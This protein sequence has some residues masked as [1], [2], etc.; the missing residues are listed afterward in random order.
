M[1]KKLESVN[2]LELWMIVLLVIDGILICIILE[3]NPGAALIIALV[4][5]TCIIVNALSAFYITPFKKK[6]F[7]GKIVKFCG[8]ILLLLAVSLY[9]WLVRAFDYHG[10]SPLLYPGLWY[11]PISFIVLAIFNSLIFYFDIKVKP[12]K[13]ESRYE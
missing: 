3:N 10:S 4:L 6:T 9:A 8:I 11:I 5:T 2:I 12:I 1:N 7:C 13:E